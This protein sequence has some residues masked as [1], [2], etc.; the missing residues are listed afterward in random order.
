MSAIKLLT[1]ANKKV[2][3]S[4]GITLNDSQSE[5]V[6]HNKG[7]LLIQAGPGSGKSTVLAA[8]IQYLLTVKS[9]RPHR[10]M[11]ITFTRKAAGELKERI[12]KLPHITSG[13]INSLAIGTFHSI[14][15]RILRAA[16]LKHEILASDNQ[17]ESMINSILK[18]QGLREDYSPEIMLAELSYLKNIGLTTK[19]LNAE[20]GRENEWLG[21]IKA[22]EGYKREKKLL[23]FDD[24]LLETKKLLE[25]DE[26][27][28][29]G[30]Q[31]QF[32]HILLDEFQ[33]ILTG[34]SWRS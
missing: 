4:S 9:V 25:I 15:L 27:L 18:D 6:M 23:D 26:Y 28:L 14:F 10:I 19:E 11:A 24:I 20:T 31:G 21:V 16:G 17:K 7:P 13:E 30:L 12:N 5:A 8:K 34:C 33:D 22:Y 3:E 2:Y 32:E 1:T 29:S